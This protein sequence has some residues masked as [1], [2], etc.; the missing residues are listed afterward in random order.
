MTTL[1]R[2]AV[3]LIVLTSVGAPA[4]AQQTS[5][6]RTD[7]GSLVIELAGD[8]SAEVSLVTTFDLT[9][10]AD[11]QG[12]ERLRADLDTVADAHHAQMRRVAARTAAETGR[13]M[14]VDEPAATAHVVET[15]GERRGVVTVRVRW[16][17][18]AAVEDDRLV[19]REPFASGFETDRPVT[20]SAP[21]GY[22]LTA[23]SPT[24]QTRTATT[25]VFDAGTAFE[26]FAVVA[27]SGAGTASAEAT[28][29]TRLPTPLASVALVSALA[30]LVYA[31]RRSR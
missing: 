1:G 14:S 15:D 21:E 28:T 23:V 26:D 4:A 19:V 2:F 13:E 29:A 5:G 10:E 16:H 25:V 9:T 17:G 22:A 30:L 6:D 31:V 27:V 8:G 20:I 11:R 12:F 7:A 18:L 3:L 24:P